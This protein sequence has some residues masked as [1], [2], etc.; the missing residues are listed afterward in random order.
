MAKTNIN[1]RTNSEIKAEAGKILA[2]LGLDMSTA[3]NL[4]LHQ[5]VNKKAI[6]FELSIEKVSEP[7]AKHK[8]V[9]GCMKG[10]IWMSDDFDEPLDELKEYM[11]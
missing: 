7:V 6:P 1:I 5:I 3:V 11:E 8:P 10:E 2:N 4:F 9:F